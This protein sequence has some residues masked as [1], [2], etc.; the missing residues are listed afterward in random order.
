MVVKIAG[1]AI[2]ASLLVMSYQIF[3]YISM[4]TNRGIGIK[5]TFL[6]S[7]TDVV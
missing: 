2:M 6:K 4:D 1:R 3:L 5:N 7:Q